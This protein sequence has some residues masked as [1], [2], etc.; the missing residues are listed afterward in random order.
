MPAVVVTAKATASGPLS[1]AMRRSAAAVSSSASS[2]LM[3]CHPGSGSPFGR[4]RRRG[5]SSRSGASTSSGEARPLAQSALPVGCDGSGSSATSRPPSTTASQPQR[6]VQRGQKAE[7]RR[8]KASGMADPSANSPGSARSPSLS[9]CSGASGAADC[10]QL[11]RFVRRY[12][13][14]RPGQPAVA[15]HRRGHA[16]RGVD[17]RAQIIDAEVDCRQWPPHCITSA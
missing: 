6:E 14:R 9:R 10:Q 7:M 16:E 4:V 13:C 5:N 12:L 17:C 2:Q 1:A 8:R 11:A 3:R 15:L